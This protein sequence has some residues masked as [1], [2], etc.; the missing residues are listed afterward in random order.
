[1]ATKK[2]V[3]ALYKL[4]KLFVERKELTADDPYILNMLE[5]SQRTLERY[6]KELQDIYGHIITIKRVRKKYYKLVSI[7]DIIEEFIKHSDDISELLQMAREFD[8]EILKDLEKSTLKKLATKD[9]SIFVFRNYTMEGLSDPKVKEYF[10][11]L[12]GAIKKDK[13][14]NI[15][16]KL[17][18]ESFFF[19]GA[20]PLK[21]VF[22]N[23]N[24]YVAIVYDK[25]E[26]QLL[27]LNFITDIS[28]SNLKVKI[29]YK[30]LESYLS[31]L[32]YIQSA[33]T[34]YGKAKKVAKIKA[35]PNVAHYFREHMKKLL[36]SQKFIKECED[37]SVIFSL[38]YTQELEVL[39]LIQKWLPDL[40]I[41]SPKEL[42]RA[43]IKKL[44]TTLENQIG[45][46][47]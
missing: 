12:K 36:P 30:D 23:N 9:N 45:Q 38:E 29:E 17:G 21:L 27:Q 43:Y 15:S 14:L 39:P 35:T 25:K 40:I 16:Y 44:Q 6:F 46:I 3:L 8:P 42:Q 7:S 37:G 19:S 28:K 18:K 2:K 10:N 1:M 24:W 22:I 13:S 31:F 32:K 33:L 26:L 41:L 5:C 20:K 11:Y 47:V 34:L 4:I